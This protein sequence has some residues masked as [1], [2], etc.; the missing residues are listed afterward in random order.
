MMIRVSEQSLGF[1]RVFI[2]ASKIYVHFSLQPCSLKIEKP[3]AHGHKVPIQIQLYRHLKKE[4][5]SR[6]PVLLIS[7]LIRK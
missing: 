2:E 1:V 3:A 5:L 4:Y 6:D 7:K